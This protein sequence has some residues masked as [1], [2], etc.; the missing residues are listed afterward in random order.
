MRGF[1]S[2]GLVALWLCAMGALLL[3]F[4]GLSCAIV[5][6]AASASRP[7]PSPSPTIVSEITSN[8]RARH[9]RSLDRRLDSGDWL[10]SP[11]AEQ[12]L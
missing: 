12:N 9:R 6:R 3:G 11:A 7:A 10:L 1:W 2:S 8:E 4:I 5:A